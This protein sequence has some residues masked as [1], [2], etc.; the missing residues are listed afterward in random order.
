V[1]NGKCSRGRN[2]NSFNECQRDN[3]LIKKMEKL[4]L[5]EKK[6]LDNEKINIEQ[7]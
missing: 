6:K 2:G 4:K 3:D 1:C 5:K 7:N